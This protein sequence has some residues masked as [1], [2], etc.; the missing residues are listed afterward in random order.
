M[1]PRLGLDC[2][3]K[4]LI[5]TPV[6]S[7]RLLPGVQGGLRPPLRVVGEGFQNKIN[8]TAHCV[9]NLGVRAKH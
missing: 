3:P 5:R 9:L 4:A 1:R 2:V 7:Q 8:K 6:V